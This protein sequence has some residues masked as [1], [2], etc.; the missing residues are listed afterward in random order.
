MKPSVTIVGGGLA[1]TEA[2]LLLAHWGIPVT[3]Y[4]MR[5]ATPTPAHE[6]GFLAELVCSNSLRSVDPLV[7]AGLLKE[8]LEQL[9]S[10]LM[11]AAQKYRVPAGSA[12]AV[13]RAAF[14]AGLTLSVE[15]HP[16][17]TLV[18]EAVGKLPEGLTILTPGPLASGPLMDAIRE[19]VGKDHL[20]FFDAIAPILDADS[21]DMDRLFR[22][23]RYDR[24][25]PDY[26]NVALDREAYFR[27][28]EALGSGEQFVPHEFDA[29][30]K[31]PLFAGCQPIEAIAASG[32]LSLA[33]GPM[34]PVGFENNPLGRDLFA[35][36][37]LRAENLAGT[38]YNLVGFQTRLK[39][40][41]QLRVFRLL[42]GLERA[43]FLRYG[44]LHRNSYLDGPR[45][46]SSDLSMKQSSQ[47]FVG[48]Q[49]AGGEGYVE[50]IALGHLA[51]RFVADRMAGRPPC[52][53]PEET[54]L[55]AIHHHVTAAMEEP[56]QPSNIH[57]GLFPPVR[58]R[59]KR[60]KREMM[61][62]RARKALAQ[63]TSPGETTPPR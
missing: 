16:A 21:L 10:P 40:R 13:D 18:R 44:S 29:G 63:W 47:T 49:F 2:A 34:R 14:A 11:A 46:L 33:H 6:S 24:G 54:A 58:A 15:R 38:A 9:G 51:A 22:A 60:A 45:I 19:V 53:P 41:E 36:V 27:F 26:L 32:P 57:W 3:L 43:E 52:L 48:G 7:A 62:A 1:G 37:Q 30:D 20:F 55:G 42:P 61:L 28:I 56:I 59:G 39:Q 8:E 25:E 35:V 4:E 23:T 12:L 31:L 17:I 50:S 5:P